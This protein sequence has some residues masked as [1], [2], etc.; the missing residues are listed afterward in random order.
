MDEDLIKNADM[1]KI[2]DEGQ[3]IYEEIKSKYEPAQNGKFLAIEVD[4]K[5]VYLADSTVEA[6]EVAKKE[7]P[8]KVFYVVKIGFDYVETMANYFL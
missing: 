5:D 7:H 4:S 1:Q 2:G 6:V 8:N 3:K